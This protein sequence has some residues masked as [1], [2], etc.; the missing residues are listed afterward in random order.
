ME[1][2]L[3]DIAIGVQA[4]KTASAIP[5]CA[6]F[7]FNSHTMGLQELIPDIHLVDI[8]DNKT[9]MIEALYG[10]GTLGTSKTMQG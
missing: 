10:G 3:H 9:N 2:Y 1:D 6:R 5:V 4:I 8:I 7:I